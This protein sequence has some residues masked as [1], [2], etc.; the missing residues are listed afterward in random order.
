MAEITNNSSDYNTFDEMKVDTAKSHLLREV[1]EAVKFGGQYHD[2]ELNLDT[3]MSDKH[4]IGDHPT[5][6]NFFDVI[7]EDVGEKKF[8]LIVNIKEGEILEGVEAS[9]GKHI[10][11]FNDLDFTTLGRILNSCEIV[12]LLNR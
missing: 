4:F 2:F 10:V 7:V 5:N 12:D 9:V 1:K 6:G 11:E 3:I 8:K